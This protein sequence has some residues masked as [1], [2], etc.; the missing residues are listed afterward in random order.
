MGRSWIRLNVCWWTETMKILA[1]LLL[2]VVV[3]TGRRVSPAERL[4]VCE[5]EEAV[6]LTCSN[7]EDVLYVKSSQV[8]WGRATDRLCPSEGRFTRPCWGDYAVRKIVADCHDAK[9]CSIIPETSQLGTGC[10]ETSNYLQI[11]YS[12]V[13]PL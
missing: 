4:V 8:F 7:P 9:E 12:C 13:E 3:V 6:T 1:L 10:P 2:F 11:V 5:G